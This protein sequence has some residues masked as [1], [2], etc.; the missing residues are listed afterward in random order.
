MKLLIE[1]NILILLVLLAFQFAPAQEKS[2]PLLIDSFTYS[3]SEDA[4]VRLDYWRIELDKTPQNRGFV[5][6]YGGQA[7]KRGEVEAHLRGIKQAF[8]LKRIDKKRVI[9]RTG[10]FRGKLTVELWILPENSSAPLPTPTIAVNKVRFKGVSRKIIPY[11]C[12]F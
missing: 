7:G 10:G 9:L 6:V 2:N 5:I 11:E 1:K 4:S 12:C 8:G 3:N